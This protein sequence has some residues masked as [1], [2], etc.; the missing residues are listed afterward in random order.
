[1]YLNKAKCRPENHLQK[2]I[3][4]GQNV[5]DKPLA[6][7]Q[8]Q[9]AISGLL[10]NSTLNKCTFTFSYPMPMDKNKDKAK[11]CRITHEVCY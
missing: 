8:I 4:S 5:S 3:V 2:N 10:R 9:T 7:T 6:E 11:Y 1:M